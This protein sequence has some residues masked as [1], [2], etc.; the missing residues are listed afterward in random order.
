MN[1]PIE[2]VAAVI[3]D[4]SGRYLL[5]RKHGTEAFMQPGGK[6]EEGE[7]DLEALARELNEELGLAIVAG[8]ERP[9][10]VF[11]AQ[12][13][14]E[15]D[16]DVVAAV[17]E[18][19]VA[20]S[21]IAK[22]EIAE[23]LWFDPGDPP[24]V[25][26]APLTR[27]HILRLWCVDERV[28]RVSDNARRRARESAVGASAISIKHHLEFG[29]MS[30]GAHLDTKRLGAIA[31][32]GLLPMTFAVWAAFQLRF[33]GRVP[34]LSVD[35]AWVLL[36]VG[37]SGPVGPFLD[38][39]NGYTG[40]LHLYPLSLI[41]E[42]FGASTVV[43]RTV[44]VVTNAI[45]MTVFCAAIQRLWRSWTTTAIT[46][47]L[48]FCLPVFAAFDRLGLELTAVL[49]LLLAIAAWFAAC[50]GTL[51]RW[52]LVNAFLAG[53][54]AGFAVFTHV[55]ALGVAT[56][57][58]VVAI[59]RRPIGVL[60]LIPFALGAAVGIVPRLVLWLGQTPAG[61][62]TERAFD[63][64]SRLQDM[65]SIPGVLAGLW[66]GPLVY[67]R[68]AGLEPNIL[69]PVTSLTLIAAIVVRVIGIAGGVRFQAIE[70]LPPLALVLAVGI[71][72]MIT[73]A[74]SL[75]YFVL[76]IA[77]LVVTIA[78]LF[79]RG[80]EGSSKTV[81][82]G[83]TL[84][85]VLACGWHLVGQESWLNRPFLEQ[86]NACVVFPLGHRLSETSCHFTDEADLYGYLVDHGVSDVVTP[87][88]IGWPLE[89]LDS[90]SYRLT[91]H[92]IGGTVPTNRRVAIVAYDAPMA[93]G[94]NGPDLRQVNVL[95]GLPRQDDSP[96]N[97]IV[98]MN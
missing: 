39:M 95:A 35:E 68:F 58:V 98:F 6:R 12:A 22:A 47:A 85:I 56:A 97:F 61:T 78:R 89:V 43:L 32:W 49:P 59:V 15:S 73:P 23:L 50:A 28:D 64:G 92:P 3:R 42:W 87:P 9:L 75:R 11:R 93:A 57:V 79:A 1:P 38:G 21:A 40:G 76:P 51:P 53:L 45:A 96:R 8:S 18:V 91:L 60:R 36:R 63:F 17:Y 10:G 16:R 65:A 46:A 14:N 20:G 24:P 27:D 44:A 72:V 5:V 90:G 7:D 86:R 48:L 19:A 67:L 29:E 30:G 70:L 33:A 4:A 26:V 13:A 88:F 25:A 62:L 52:R 83:A 55:I 94:I 80:L 69:V 81:R 77:F 31:L 37:S 71:V 66:D 34:G 2:I 84:V 74:L 54:F 82:A 41:T